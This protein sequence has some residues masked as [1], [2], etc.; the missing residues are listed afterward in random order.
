MRGAQSTPEATSGRSSGSLWI[1]YY[2]GTELY[3]R[4][5]GVDVKRFVNCRFSMT[6]WQL[7]GVVYAYKSFTL[8]GQWDWG[9]GGRAPDPPSLPSFR[10]VT[11]CV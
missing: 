4:V 10:K 9:H 7:A 6:F 2:W 11:R 8:H 1:D 5:L 3:P